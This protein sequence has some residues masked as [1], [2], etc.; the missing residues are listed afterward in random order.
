MAAQEVNVGTILN[1]A[2]LISYY[3]LQ[4]SSSDSG[5]GGNTGTDTAIT[6]SAGNGKFGTG[7]GFNASSSKISIGTAANLNITGSLSFT[8][9]MKNG[10]QTGGKGL[11]GKGNNS[12]GANIESW[13]ALQAQAGEVIFYTSNGTTEKT[14]TSA[15]TVT[16]SVYHHVA[17]TYDPGGT[18]I[19][20]TDG[21]PGG[22]LTTAAT[23]LVALAGTPVLFG[24]TSDGR[25]YGGVLDDICIFKRVL[26]AAEVSNF[27]NGW[28][29][30]QVAYRSLLGVGI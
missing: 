18:M 13:G 27:Y 10:T 7:A 4:G 21:T 2:N 5:T 14:V 17:C 24:A 19:V 30:G 9:W 12:A 3:R 23:A 8:F 16:N 11:V 15:G 20:Y 25:F 6:Y 28:P 29:T 22:T 26:T 1:D